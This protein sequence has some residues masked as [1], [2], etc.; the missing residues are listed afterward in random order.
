LGEAYLALARD[1]GDRVRIAMGLGWLGLMAGDAGD[2]P[3]S[4]SLLREA[5]EIVR[6]IN[7]QGRLAGLLEMLAKT[8]G[9]AGQGATACRLLGAAEAQREVLSKV[10]YISR[11]ELAR[12]VT[13]IRAMLSPGEFAT[14]WTAGR[15]LSWD[16]A[17]ALLVGIA[18]ALERGEAAI[19][20]SQPGSLM[21]RQ[22]EF[23][24]TRREREI[25]G[26]LCQRL[27]NPEIAERL[28]ISRST[29]ATHV[30]NLLAKLGAANRREA[31]AIAVRQGLI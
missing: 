24:L 25:L 20:P 21:V 6:D 16:Q 18:T 5:A 28:F 8:T 13:A 2:L 9:A 26:L 31:A 27:T 19:V 7:S 4:A 3:R 10:R 29:V 14:Q 23:D 22:A 17:L 12:D 11:E 30:I 1:V 15:R